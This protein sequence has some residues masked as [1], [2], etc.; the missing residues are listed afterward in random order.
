MTVI[1]SAPAKN[2]QNKMIMSMII[3]YLP[4][5]LF[6]A[7]LLEYLFNLTDLL[8]DS[9]ADF[10]SLTFGRQIGV[11]SRFGPLSLSLRLSLREACTAAWSVVLCFMGSP[12]GRLLIDLD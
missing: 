5:F 9:S 7:L 2:Q 10:L 6:R 8:P 1:A 3:V 4:F 11:V 12:F